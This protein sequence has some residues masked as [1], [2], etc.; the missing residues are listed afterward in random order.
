M[1]NNYDFKINPEKISGE[2]IRSHMDFDVLLK[3]SQATTNGKTL[4]GIRPIILWMSAVAAAACVAALFVGPFAIFG[5][6]NNAVPANALAGP[7]LPAAT[8]S[9]IS[10]FFASRGANVEAEGKVKLIAPSLSF[11]DNRGNWIENEISLQYDLLADCVDFFLAGVNLK[12]QS[13]ET[14]GALKPAGML[15]VSAQYGANS[16]SLQK[17]LPTEL[18]LPH[19]IPDEE[20]GLYKIYYWQANLRNWVEKPDA[21]LLWQNLAGGYEQVIDDLEKRIA[22]EQAKIEKDLPLPAKPLPPAKPN[23]SSPTLEID[24]SG[25]PHKNKAQIY[26]GTIWEVT[27][28][29]ETY[30]KRALRSQWEIAEIIQTG[31]HTYTLTLGTG[32]S[33]VTLKVRPVLIGKAY[34][35]AQIS[36]N[37]RQETYDKAL[38]KRQELVQ[39]RLRPLLEELEKAKLHPFCKINFSIDALGVW[40]CAK[41]VDLKPYSI[42]TSIPSALTSGKIFIADPENNILLESPMGSSIDF[43][44]VAEAVDNLQ[45]WLWSGENQFYTGSVIHNNGSQMLQIDSTGYRIP[46]EPTLRTYLQS[47]LRV[48]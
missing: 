35:N 32:Q 24:Y 23:E 43:G 18:T 27:S 30:D 5:P 7:N 28:P 19:A 13:N 38:Q 29:E 1:A 6:G 33:T 25:L 12:I 40:A 9:Q 17:T 44:A 42:T 48:N 47:N 14:I 41:A 39:Q 11:M 21:G 45:F 15:E 31:D 20:R 26:D 36:F 46:D 34:Q 3:S 16:L 8:G 2:T 10:T 4:R 37:A 22:A